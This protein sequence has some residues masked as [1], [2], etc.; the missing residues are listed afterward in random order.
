MKYRIGGLWGTIQLI[1]TW[2]G[3]LAI[4]A[5]CVFF[6]VALKGG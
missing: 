6:A 4:V 5:G 2:L 1:M 3:A